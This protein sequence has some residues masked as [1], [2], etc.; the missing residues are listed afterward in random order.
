M[1]KG[2]YSA[3]GVAR[4]LILFVSDS[5]PDAFDKCQMEDILKWSADEGAHCDVLKSLSG[6]AVREAFNMQPV[7]V[8][9]WTYY[10]GYCHSDALKAL[11]Q[12]SEKSLIDILKSFNEQGNSAPGIHSVAR[13]LIG[14]S[15]L[16]VRSDE[17]KE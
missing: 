10:L 1:D 7:M 2:D 15:A 8:P 3:L 14:R 16:K 6:R 5:M 11:Q 13:V 4:K 12:A 9:C 17:E